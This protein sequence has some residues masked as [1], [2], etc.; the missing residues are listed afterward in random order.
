[1]KETQVERGFCVFFL[2]GGLMW[3]TMSR[4][5]RAHGNVIIQRDAMLL[6]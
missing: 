2:E 5:T 3:T 1:M 6:L 4:T